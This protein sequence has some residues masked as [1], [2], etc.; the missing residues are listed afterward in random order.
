MIKVIVKIKHQK[1][2]N[3]FLFKYNIKLFKLMQFF[4][5]QTSVLIFLQMK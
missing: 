2:K 5:V 1:H 3:Q 4:W